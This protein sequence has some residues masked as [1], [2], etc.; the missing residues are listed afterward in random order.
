[1]EHPL[2][3]PRLIWPGLVGALGATVVEDLLDG[4]HHVLTTTLQDELQ[5][6]PLVAG[7]HSGQDVDG[8]HVPGG[9]RGRRRLLLVFV[10][11]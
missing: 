1:M 2:R 7:E 5:D 4:L 8:V 10:G 3:R 11:L 6:A 9:R